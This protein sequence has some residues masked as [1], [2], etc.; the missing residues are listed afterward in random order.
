MLPEIVDVV[1]DRVEVLLDGGV[2]RGTDV[3]KALGLGARDCLIARPYM[4]GLA[5]GGAAGV[6]R[7]IDVLVSEIDRTMAP[8][9]LSLAR[10][11]CRRSRPSGSAIGQI[12]NL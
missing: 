1:G 5:A 2:R 8:A 11:D 3:V 12:T 10:G 9:R 4:Y 7:S 6:L